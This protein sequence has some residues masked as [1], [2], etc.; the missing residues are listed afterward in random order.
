MQ[1]QDYVRVFRSRWVSILILTLLGGG[2]GLSSAM[3]MAPQ[4]E[5]QTQLFASVKAAGSAVDVTQGN[6][7]AEKRVIS[8]ISLATS[9]R[10][11]HAASQS[12][13]LSDGQ[14]SGKVFAS[15]PPQTVLIDVKATSGDPALAAKIANAVATELIRAVNE[16]EDVSLVKLSVFESAS[17]PSAPASPKLPVNSVA[18]L[19]AGLILGVG[20]ALTRN[21]LDTRLRTQDDIR[22]ITDSGILG[23]LGHYPEAQNHPLVTQDDPYS[24]RAESFRQLRTHL[25]FTN[26]SGGSQSVVVTS[27]I[28]GEGKSSTSVNLAIM[29]AESGTKVLLVDADLRRPKIATYLGIDGTVGLTSVLTNTVELADAIQPWGP[30]GQ[31][32]V[33][34]S[35]KFAPNPSELLGS[36]RMEKLM[37]RFETE[38]EVVIIDAPPLLPVTDPAVLGSI[39]SGVLLVVSADGRTRKAELNAAL[40]SVA[41]VNARVLGLVL[42]RMPIVAGGYGY[43]EYRPDSPGTTPPMRRAKSKSLRSKRARSHGQR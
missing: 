38:Y 37:A 28:P 18:G 9:P 41:A 6:S 30:G 19:M 33:L 8:Y 42:N 14:L 15:S 5:A 23:T 4:Y 17:V 3:L 39:S 11:L 31:M 12:L 36:S 7:F 1:L 16:V 26:L 25:H 21:A 35:G 27:S 22:K 2:A 13:G 20:F 32:D 43:S 24:P 29:L 40:A 10:V 34:T